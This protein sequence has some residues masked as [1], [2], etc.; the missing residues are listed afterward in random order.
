MDNA[1]KKDGLEEEID[2]QNK[3]LKKYKDDNAAIHS[4]AKHEN[5]LKTYEE[6]RF[7]SS[8]V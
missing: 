7:F 8:K 1:T 5:E 2:K 4:M 6:S 3:L